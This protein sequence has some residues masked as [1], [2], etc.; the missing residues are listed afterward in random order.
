VTDVLLRCCLLHCYSCSVRC[1][2]TAAQM[3]LQTLLMGGVRYPL[4]EG[5]APVVNLH[6]ACVLV[7]LGRHEQAAAAAEVGAKEFQLSI[8]GI[9][10]SAANAAAL[11]DPPPHASHARLR[12]ALSWIRGKQLPPSSSSAAAAAA[13]EVDA[14]QESNDDLQLLYNTGER[15]ARDVRAHAQPAAA[16]RVISLCSCR[17]AS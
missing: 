8:Q 10:I 1:L 17:A 2:L 11:T 15:V 14:R 4:P 6:K 3:L 16:C 13:A 5:A 9:S 12:H 7:M